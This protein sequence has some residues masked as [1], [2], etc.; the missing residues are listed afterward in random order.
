MSRASALRTTG[1]SSVPSTI[2]FRAS[3]GMILK[4]RVW[5]KPWIPGPKRKRKKTC[6]FPFWGG[7]GGQCPPKLWSEGLRPLPRDSLPKG[8]MRGPENVATAQAL[9]A[10][11]LCWPPKSSEGGALRVTTEGAGWGDLQHY[12]QD[13][14]GVNHV[15]NMYLKPRITSLAQRTCSCFYLR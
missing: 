15:Q 2:W 10:H 13:Q 3:P 1:L 14:T 8:T 11:G 4:C 5:S 6:S 12:V 9:H 7:W